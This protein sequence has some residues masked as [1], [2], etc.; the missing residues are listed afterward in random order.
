MWKRGIPKTM[1]T[2]C[3]KISVVML[4]HNRENLISRAI[5]SVLV[6]SFRDFEFIIVDNGGTDR[7]G[8]IADEYAT[9]DRRVR[10]IHR[11]RGNIGAGRN[12]GIDAARGEWI[13]FI[14]DDDWCEPDFL[15]FLYN[16][17]VE[18]DADIAIC[19]AFGKVFA[20]RRVYSS[21]EAVTE[22]LWRKR[23]NVQFPTKLIRRSLF[24]CLRFSESAK[25]DDIELM[26]QILAG[27]DRVAYHGLPKY[28][29]YRHEGNNSGWTT[30]HSLLNAETLTEYLRVY[31]ERTA[32][33]CER[34]PTDAAIWRY[35]E[36][37]F[38]ISMVEKVTRLNLADCYTLRDKLTAELASN[39]AEF[40][41]GDY[42]LEFEKK[43]M[44]AFIH[45]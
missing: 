20:E 35:F 39:R 42:I 9:Q 16:L 15:E 28:T 22:L 26:P 32:W 21:S 14:D 4:T 40:L 37:S 3:N 19:G 24:E 5:E 31:R 27:A 11:G 44:E 6:Q 18:N 25:Y 38:W 30:N 23:F 41:T 2:G 33:L 10:V 34:F 17:A 12:T 29:F 8:V 1:K 7:S 13:A 36:W 45:E 43:W